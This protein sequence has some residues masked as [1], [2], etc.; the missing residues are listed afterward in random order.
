MPG[1]N[2]LRNQVWSIAHREMVSFGNNDLNCLRKQTLPSL[3]KMERIIAFAEDCQKR[4]PGER[5]G[6]GNSNL[7]IQRVAMTRVPHVIV[8]GAPGSLRRT[9]TECV[10][11]GF[12]EMTSDAKRTGADAGDEIGQDIDFAEDTAPD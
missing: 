1:T 7:F 3:L 5:S 8:K 2:R 9:C 11:T 4:K 10:A 12:V 6:E